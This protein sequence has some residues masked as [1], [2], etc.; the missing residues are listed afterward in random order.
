MGRNNRNIHRRRTRYYIM[1][2]DKDGKDLH[3]TRFQARQSLNDP[4]KQQTVLVP[5]THPQ[6][7]KSKSKL[8][9]IAFRSKILGTIEGNYRV[10]VFA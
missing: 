6:T 7:L 4:D 1:T 2:T 3:Y 9:A 5:S 8:L 10:K